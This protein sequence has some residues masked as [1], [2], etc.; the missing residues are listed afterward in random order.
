[1]V[2]IRKAK[3]HREAKT[4]LGRCKFGSFYWTKPRWQTEVPTSPRTGW[5][6]IPHIRGSSFVRVVSWNGIAIRDWA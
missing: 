4:E 5:T 2:E 3:A 6:S 1:M